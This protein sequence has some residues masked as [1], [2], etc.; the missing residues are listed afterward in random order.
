[1]NHDDYSVFEDE[2]AGYLVSV[3]DIMAGLLFIFIIT[4]VAFVIQYQDAADKTEQEKI[5]LQEVEE[6]KEEERTRLEQTVDQLTNNRRIRK[7]LLSRIEDH[8]KARGVE[9]EVDQDRGVLRLTEKTV[10]FRTNKS[11]LDAEPRQNLAVIAEVLA[12]LL[13]C[14]AGGGVEAGPA[15]DRQVRGKLE[16]VFVEGHTDNVPVRG[17]A[18]FNW[19][20]A[21]QRAIA[22]YQYLLEQEPSLGR[23]LNGDTRNPEPLFSVSGYA[24]QRP[25]IPHDEPTDEPLN[26]RIDMRFIM[27]PPKETPEIIR[28]IQDRGVR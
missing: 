7:H 25:L 3:S 28:A 14:Y 17:I 15:C 2:G 18:D 21:A 5:E 26:R 27:T 10:Q 6:R 24:D 13:P 9:V 19:R 4:L 11:E 20:L 1:V 23:L 16:A 22:T 8:L 12:E